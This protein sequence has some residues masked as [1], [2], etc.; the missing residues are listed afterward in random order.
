MSHFNSSLRLFSDQRLSHV[1]IS[2]L[3]GVP[4]KLVPHSL[5]YA[6]FCQLR[7]IKRLVR[8]EQAEKD[9]IT[10]VP[11]NRRLA[12]LQGL[13]W[14]EKRCCRELEGSGGS[15]AVRTRSPAPFRGRETEGV[16]LPGGPTLSDSDVTVTTKE[17]CGGWWA[18]PETSFTC[19]SGTA[20]HPLCSSMP[21]LTTSGALVNSPVLKFLISILGLHE[22]PASRRSW[23]LLRKTAALRH[24]LPLKQIPASK[25][26]SSTQSRNQT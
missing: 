3:E 17:I 13:A 4:G 5:E 11:V 24:F 6:D 7:N 16:K 2:C 14:E 18:P 15:S 12:K 20:E 25:A 19:D 10:W 1:L 23:S 22:G 9:L 8:E 26:G 21:G